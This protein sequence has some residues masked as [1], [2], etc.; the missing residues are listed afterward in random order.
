MF[1]LKN[2][3]TNF[4]QICSCANRRNYHNRCATVTY[5]PDYPDFDLSLWSVFTQFFD[6]SW[7][8]PSNRDKITCLVSQLPLLSCHCKITPRSVKLCV[9]NRVFD[10]FCAARNEALLRA[11]G[12][13]S[14]PT[15]VCILLNISFDDSYA[16]VGKVMQ[17]NTTMSIKMY[18]MAILDN[19]MFRPLLAIFRLSSRELKVLLC[20]LRAHV[21][22]RSV[23]TGLIA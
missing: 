14:A 23:H 4:E 16:G 18:L 20:A 7:L 6:I 17:S 15:T 10:C 11:S 13:L 5:S 22:Q 3:K 9:S 8:V 1:Q 2:Y 21:M 19:H 12:A